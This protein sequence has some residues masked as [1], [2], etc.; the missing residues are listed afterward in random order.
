MYCVECGAE[1]DELC[2]RCNRCDHCCDCGDDAEFDDAEMGID[3]EE[4]KA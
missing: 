1:Q 2:K 4:E 3:P